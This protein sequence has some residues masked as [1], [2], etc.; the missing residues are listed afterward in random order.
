MNI[1]FDKFLI[2]LLPLAAI[3]FLGAIAYTVHRYISRPSKAHLASCD[4]IVFEAVPLNL[5]CIE[6]DLADNGW[7]L[8][9][10]E[11]TETA[12]L[13]YRFQKLGAGAL[14]L[15]EI[16]DFD[17]SMPRTCNR[18]TGTDSLI[19]IQTHGSSRKTSF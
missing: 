8:T 16:F 3:L 18:T 7:R 6:A 2:E 13:L 12:A 15:S 5:A 11:T 10:S 19:K 4:Y 17:K 14:C 1:W 9:D